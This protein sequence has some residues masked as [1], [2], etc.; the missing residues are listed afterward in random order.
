MN[1]DWLK[2]SQIA[3]VISVFATATSTIVLI[4]SAVLVLKQLRQQKE[5]M[6]AQTKLSKIANA[7]ALVNISSAL[8]TELTKDRKMAEFWINGPENFRNYDP[9]DQFR[10]KN[11][12]IW[13]LIFHEN[14]FYQ[15]QND[16]LDDELYSSW[17]RDFR[18]FI[19]GQNLEAHWEDIRDSYHDDFR[20]YVD[21]LVKPAITQAPNKSFHRTPRLRA[22]HVAIALFAWIMRT[23]RR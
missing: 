10:Y 6:Q 12:L 9:V 23:R 18:H 5:Q 8:N 3:T 7:Q 17:D 1:I 2:A 4:V 15:K 16:L 20:L 19:K 21:G 13:W 11:L 14:I 22:S